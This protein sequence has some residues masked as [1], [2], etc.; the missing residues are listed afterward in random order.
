VIGASTK[1][2]AEPNSMPVTPRH[3]LATLADAWDHVE[4]PPVAESSLLQQAG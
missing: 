4:A 2:A 3:L 1:D